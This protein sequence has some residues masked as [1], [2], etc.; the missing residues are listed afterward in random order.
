[1][2]VWYVCKIRTSLTVVFYTPIIERYHL[3]R[4]SF[5]TIV[6]GTLKVTPQEVRDASLHV[7]D[8]ERSTHRYVCSN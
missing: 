3:T 6:I 8:N 1:M 7:P 4:E 5:G 2:W